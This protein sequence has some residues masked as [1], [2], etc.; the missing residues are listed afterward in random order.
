VTFNVI[1]PTVVPEVIPYVNQGDN[2]LALS[3][4]ITVVGPNGTI[5]CNGEDSSTAIPENRIVAGITPANFGP[6]NVH[7]VFVHH[8]INSINTVAQTWSIG[9]VDCADHA[10]TKKRVVFVP[11]QYQYNLSLQGVALTPFQNLRTGTDEF[12]QTVA[13]EIGHSLGMHHS[14]QYDTNLAA[15]CTHTEN[16]YVAA[17]STDYRDSNALM[18]PYKPS[19]HHSLRTHIGAPHWFELNDLNPQPQ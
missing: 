12:Y 8:F 10:T 4:G 11:D 18:W 5:A 3:Q 13:H 7:L 15:G 9:G 17:D 19:D 6:T 1:A 16:P 2:G 14:C